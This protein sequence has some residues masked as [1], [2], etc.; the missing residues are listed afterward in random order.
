M[1]LFG[2]GATKYN[3]TFD[4]YGFESDR[5]T[6]KEGEEVTVTYD[7][8]ATDTDYSFFA[9][10]D[11]V[12]LNQKFDSNHGY[13][14]TF[15][16]PAHDVKI[17]VKSRNSM[18]MDPYANMPEDTASGSP[19]DCITDAYLLFDYYEATVATVGGD[20]SEEYCLYEY[21]DME[22]V[23][24]R[25][26]KT[27]DS[28]ETM[29]YCTVPVS[30][31]DDC[32]DLVKKYKMRKWKDGSGLRGMKYV[33]KFMDDGE[34]KRVSSDEMPDNGRDAFYAIRDVLGTAWGQYYSALD[35]ETWFCPECGA[36]NNRR[37]CMDCGI[38]KPE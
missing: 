24:V 7:M 11:D 12:E 32:M 35:A 10:S 18:E 9:D 19:K 34:L 21:N 28:E 8:I 22:L 30:V 20:E 6:Y 17:S 27:E 13:V 1:G 25:Y 15:T 3:L 33:V 38:E 37:Y 23:L 36:K 31:L 5:T 29:V 2:C 16:M 4:G 14:F 26:S